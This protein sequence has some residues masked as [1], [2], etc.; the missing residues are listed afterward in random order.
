MGNALPTY[1]ESGYGYAVEKAPTTK[2]WTYPVYEELWNYGFPQ[3]MHHFARCVRGKETPIATGEDG[4]IVQEVLLAGYRSARMGAKI[5]L[6]FRPSGIKRPIDLWLG[7]RDESSLHDGDDAGSRSSGDS[8]ECRRLTE[9]D[10]RSPRS[11]PGENREHGLAELGHGGETVARVF[12][13]AALDHL[14]DAA[15]DTGQGTRDGRDDRRGI[16]AGMLAIEHV[17]RL[18]LERKPAGDHLEKHDAEGIDIGPDVDRAGIAE[19]L[20]GHV[21]A[22]AQPGSRSGQARVGGSGGHDICPR[23]PFPPWSAWAWPWRP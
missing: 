23:F 7:P 18:A 12:P 20:G 1:S 4:R 6:P 21:G 22:G 19:L 14:V 8:A 10:L 16:V 3:E 11:D 2:G 15:G 13:Q 5:G 17:Q 9:S